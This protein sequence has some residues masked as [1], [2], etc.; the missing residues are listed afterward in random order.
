MGKFHSFSSDK[1]GRSDPGHIDTS[2]HCII[3][4]PGLG[5]TQYLP[6]FVNEVKIISSFLSG[7]CHVCWVIFVWMILQ[8]LIKQNAWFESQQQ[9]WD[10]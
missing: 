2:Q 7:T 4:N 10:D 9:N 6:C 3:F 5:V 8:H 1:V